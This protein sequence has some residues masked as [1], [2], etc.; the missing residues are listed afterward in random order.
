MKSS[1][2]SG[3]FQRP[4]RGCPNKPRLTP[5]RRGLS[6]PFRRPS[7]GQGGAVV[8]TLLLALRLGVGS[9]DRLRVLRQVLAVGHPQPDGLVRPPLPA[10]DPLPLREP[11]PLL[12]RPPADG[13]LRQADD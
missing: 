11:P 3:R 4:R 1:H 7:G 10:L 2:G 5:K 13:L 6:D 12:L 8:A 9:L